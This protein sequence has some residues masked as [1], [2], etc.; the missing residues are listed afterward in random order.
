[1]NYATV[2]DAVE[3]GAAAHPRPDRVVVGLRGRAAAARRAL[4]GL[5]R[6][7]ARPGPL[8]PHARALHARQ[9]GQR[10]RPLHR[11][12]DRAAHLRERPLL[13]RRP[14]GLAVGLRQA[15]AGHRR[16]LRG[17]AAV[18]LRGRTRRP[19]RA[20]ARA[21]API[22][23]LWS[24]YL[25]DQW[26]IGDWD[27]MRAGR[28]RRSSCRGWPTCMTPPD[29]PPQNLKEYDPEWGR[30][31]WTG[32]VA[33]SCDHE[34]MLRAVQGARC[35]SPTTS[36]SSTSRAS[37]WARCPTS[38]PTRVRALLGGGRRARRLPVVRRRWA[39]RCTA[40]TRRSSPTPSSTGWRSWPADRAWR[41]GRYGSR[42]VPRGSGSGRSR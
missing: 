20:S 7:P 34:R 1:M 4:P 24:T 9:H 6:R 42:T 26:S 16:P 32:T 19:A 13:R 12:R 30:A 11:P 15:R 25:G 3:A 14:L 35:C 8:D 18:Q 27:G 22:F 41:R 28:P 23:H 31:F 10:P 17:P 5:R 29:E 36:A 2:G 21:S 33:A 37:S 39:T 40:R 38:R